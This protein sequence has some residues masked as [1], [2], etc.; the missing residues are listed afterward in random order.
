MAGCAN[1]PCAPS[2]IVMV[3]L[4]W[5]LHL[6]MPD[7]HAKYQ[8]RESNAS[9]THACG[10]WQSE[11]GTSRLCPLAKGTLEGK[12]PLRTPTR[13]LLLLL[14]ATGERSEEEPDGAPD[15]RE[16]TERQ[17]AT[18]ATATATAV[19]RRIGLGVVRLARRVMH[20]GRRDV[21]TPESDRPAAAPHTRVGLVDCAGTRQRHARWLVTDW[22]GG[23]A[24]A[25]DQPKAKV[26][27]I[28]IIIILK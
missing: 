17:H 18:S 27:D 23:M 16:T 21:E 7:Q 11:S 4:T 6:R 25:E 24:Q 14:L 22:H 26:I 12:A 9:C 5:P 3:S 13:P 15:A 28:A 19:M 2:T 8:T 10:R 1:D 20:S